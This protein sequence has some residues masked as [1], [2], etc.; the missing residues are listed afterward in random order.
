MD[1]G[2]HESISGDRFP[3]HREPACHQW[4]GPEDGPRADLDDPGDGDNND[5][6]DDFV[7]ATDEL[8]PSL[9]VF[10]NLAIAINCLSCSSHWTNDSSSSSRAKVHELDT[11]DG[12][13]STL[14][15]QR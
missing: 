8:D 14:I 4:F 1:F 13:H 9:A 2:H 5:D 11:F 15:G 6:D 7:D 12:M 10:Q 3:Y